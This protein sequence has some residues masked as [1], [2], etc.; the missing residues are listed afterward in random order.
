MNRKGRRVTA[1]GEQ[2]GSAVLTA[3]QVRE[4]RL[5]HQSGWRQSDIA[6]RFAVDSARVSRIIRRLLW[7]SV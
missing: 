7:A 2:S 5:L 1:R 3:A 4:M 6:R